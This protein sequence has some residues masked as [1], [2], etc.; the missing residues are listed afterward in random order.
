M[1][2]IPQSPTNNYFIETLDLADQANV[3]VLAESQ[4]N[5]LYTE[6]LRKVR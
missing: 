3:G 2:A 1:L 5:G 6:A 4:L